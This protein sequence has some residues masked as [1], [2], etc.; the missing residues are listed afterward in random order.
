MGPVEGNVLGHPLAGV[1]WEWP[2]DRVL[3]ESGRELRHGSGYLH[4]V[5]GNSFHPCTWKGRAVLRGDV[6]KNDSGSFVVFTE[7]GSSA[8]QRMTAKVLDVIA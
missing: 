7:H 6:V 3:M 4:T 5:N 1:L 2:F 8:S